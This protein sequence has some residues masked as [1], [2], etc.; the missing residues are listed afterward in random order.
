MTD[1]FYF[2]VRLGAALGPISHRWRGHR[3]Q[4]STRILCLSS[5][6]TEHDRSWA[7]S[8]STRASTATCPSLLAPSTPADQQIQRDDD[9]LAPRYDPS[10]RALV[11]FGSAALAR[12]RGK[13][14]TLCKNSG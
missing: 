7:E 3:Q 6:E 8:L 10:P 12:P 14:S 1:I 11:C 9:R 13:S 5:T 4:T 2:T